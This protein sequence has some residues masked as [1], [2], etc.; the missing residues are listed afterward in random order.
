MA[1]VVPI[2]ESVQTQLTPLSSPLQSYRSA[3]ALSQSM[4]WFQCEAVIAAFDWGQGARTVPRALLND[5]L[6]CQ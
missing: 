5:L 1:A 4:S 6:A 3:T 2:P